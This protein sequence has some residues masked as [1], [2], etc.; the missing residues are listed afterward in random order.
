MHVSSDTYAYLRYIFLKGQ[1]SVHSFFFDPLSCYRL[2]AFLFLCFF[3]ENIF[4]YN[5][6]PRPTATSPTELH[7]ICVNE[8][9]GFKKTDIK[10]VKNFLVVVTVVQTS[11]P[12]P[13]IVKKIKHCPH[14]LHS[15]NFIIAQS[16]DGCAIIY[17]DPSNKSPE[18]RATK[19]SYLQGCE[20]WRSPYGTRFCFPRFCEVF[21][22]I[23]EEL[24]RYMGD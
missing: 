14:A 2:H 22:R 12:G 9:F 17:V 10:I 24:T 7:C 20:C 16:S 8:F 18:L 13:V 15:E 19:T 3:F 4:S 6:P 5:S 11:G 21:K 23:F 1:C